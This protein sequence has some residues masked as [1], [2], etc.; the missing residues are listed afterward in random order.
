MDRASSSLTDRANV[1]A[2]RSFVSDPSVNPAAATTGLPNGAEPPPLVYPELLSRDDVEAYH[3]L[4]RDAV[5]FEGMNH[6][7]SVEGPKAMEALNG[8]MTNDVSE[9]AVGMG[10][11]AVA[12]TPKGKVVCDMYVVR[13]AADRFMLTVLRPYA[14][15]WL[16]LARKYIN[17]RLAKVTDESAQWVTYMLYGERAAAAVATLGGGAPSAAPLGDLMAGTLD[18]WPVW[19]HGLWT[20]GPVSVRLIR[21]P[22]MGSLPGFVIVADAH[23]GE[24]VRGQLLASTKRHASRAVWNVARVEGGRPAFGADMDE[25]TIPQEANL[26]TL[27][28]ISFTK[29]CYTGQET[30]ARVHFRGHVNRHLRGLRADQPLPQF[31]RVYDASGKDVGDVRSSVLSPR[32]GPIAMAMIRRE[33]APGDTVRVHD[34]ITATVE[35]LPFPE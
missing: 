17:P 14:P 5:W 20:I 10:L 12:L 30:V 1:H 16:D 4:R 15:A 11:H 32:L 29:G 19:S 9:L 28:A 25:H 8:L 24:V 2:P 13:T 27:G 33:V 23:D 22:V 26:D 7:S 18:E 21:A 6:W 35:A 3:D 34:G 31:A